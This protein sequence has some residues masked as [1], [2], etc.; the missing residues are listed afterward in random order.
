ME[1]ISQPENEE[2]LDSIGITEEIG[3]I[4]QS[5]YFAISPL[6]SQLYS[7][8][9]PKKVKRALERTSRVL[10][11][12]KV[13]QDRNTAIELC[14]LFCAKIT[15]D[16]IKQKL[17]RKEEHEELNEWVQLRAKY[18]RT[19]FGSKWG[20]YSIIKEFL[21][22]NGIIE[23]N[24]KS[25]FRKYCYGYRLGSNY[26]GK[27]EELYE[28]KTKEAKRLIERE[29]ERTRKELLQ[30]PICLNLI[31]FLKQVQLPTEDAIKKAA[32][33]LVRSGY[34]SKKGKLLSFLY[35]HPRK[36][37]KD[38]QSKS[39]VEEDIKIYKYLLNT[40]LMY[41]KVGSKE[42]GG[43]IK[44]S[45][46]LMPSWIRNL[47]RVNGVPFFECDYS[48]LHPNI[49]IAIYGGKGAY[50]THQKIADDLLIDVGEVKRLHLSFFNSK[51]WQIEDSE[52]YEYYKK[53]E[54]IMLHYLMIEKKRSGYKHKITPRRMFAKEV[55]IMTDVIIKLNSE[56]I[57]VGYV[58]D[59]LFCHPR[60]KLRV[61]E[62]MDE[63]VLKHG[64]KTEAKLKEAKN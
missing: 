31:E 13:H 63:I 48:C 21:I 64:V 56:G 26:K 24:Y 20:D 8:Y 38:N 25:K 3:G 62:V 15:N 32:K 54:P 59:A 18:L 23:C 2:T 35:N 47:I 33:D 52:L 60:H 49:A 7:L 30:N 14:L 36:S 55:E 4:I 61:K 27:G 42:S 58:Y 44:H 12:T 57:Y 40:S 28:F 16:Y 39:F 9:I 5:D 1:D 50:L 43:R 53:H 45:F 29:Y 10:L 11:R 17:Y 37:I 46:C 22:S 41:P 34:K 51:C 6:D 19:Y